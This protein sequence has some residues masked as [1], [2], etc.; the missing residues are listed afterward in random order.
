[1][2]TQLDQAKE[3]YGKKMKNLRLAKLSFYGW[4]S[5]RKKFG[6]K[7]LGAKGL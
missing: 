2:P 4:L 7:G 6:T 1:M 3:K 5:A